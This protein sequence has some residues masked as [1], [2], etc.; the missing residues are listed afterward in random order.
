MIYNE[1]TNNKQ[2]VIR[3]IISFVCAHQSNQL[4]FM[5]MS[6]NEMIVAYSHIL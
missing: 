6:V 3:D 5:K 1:A 4:L 2:Q